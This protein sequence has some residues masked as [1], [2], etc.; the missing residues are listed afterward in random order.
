MLHGYG[1]HMDNVHLED[2]SNFA[3]MEFW[4]P[5]FY[6]SYNDTFV[7]C[8]TD[9]SPILKDDKLYPPYGNKVGLDD[10]TA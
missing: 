10:F 6:L 5:K 9:T 1:Y 7:V 8:D 4:K 3:Q 2:L